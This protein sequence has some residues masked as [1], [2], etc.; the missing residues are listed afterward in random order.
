MLKLI[1]V[2]YFLLNIYVEV[3]GRFN[4]K[5]NQI[6]W[7]KR[8]IFSN[9]RFLITV[10]HE[11]SHLVVGV[12][13]LKGFVEL[14]VSKREETVGYYLPKYESPFKLLW[15][16]VGDVLTLL[17]GPILPPLFVTYYGELLLH[18]D[19]DMLISIVM[20][21][22]VALIIFSNQRFYMIAVLGFM[23]LFRGFIFNQLGFIFYIM[24]GWMILGMIDEVFVLIQYIQGSDSEQI[25]KGLIGVKLKLFIYLVNFIFVG[26][27]LYMI[28]LNF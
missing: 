20:W 6:Y 9:A 28:Y 19:Y 24:Y 16:K 11:L 26:Y 1:A 21:V 22:I 25:V 4:Q 23:Y 13:M 18:K 8:Y 27:Y 5:A 3:F 10:L 15:I 12:L 14:D 7:I 17:A 2:F